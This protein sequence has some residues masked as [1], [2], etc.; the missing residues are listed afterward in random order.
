M[1]NEKRIKISAVAL[2]TCA[3]T[4]PPVSAAQ[5][6]QSTTPT[7]SGVEISAKDGDRIIIDDDATIEIVRRRQ[8][9]VRTIFRQEERLLIIL[10]DYAKPGEF[11]DGKV[12]WM[13]SFYD[14]E[15]SWPLAPRWEALTTMLHYEGSSPVPHGFGLATPNGLIQ[16]SQR[17]N[18]GPKPDPTARAVVLFNGFSSGFGF[19]LSFEEAEKAQIAEAA[20]D[21]ASPKGS[22]TIGSKPAQ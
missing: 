21:R 2:V 22:M 5:N 9:T 4:C 1:K 6:P 8:A 20:R 13:F 10:V 12:D 15:G 7:R 3:V 19:G 18:D 16:L 11:P 14:I 17:Q